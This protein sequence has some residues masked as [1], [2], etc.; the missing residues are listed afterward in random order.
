MNAKSMALSSWGS[1]FEAWAIHPELLN[2]LETQRQSRLMLWC[3]VLAGPALLLVI[4]LEG[5][6]SGDYTRMLVVGIG[7]VLTCSMVV[8]LRF[9]RSLQ[10][11]SMLLTLFATAQLFSAAWWTGGISSP[12]I[13]VYPLATIF[14]A[15][16]GTIWMSLACSLLLLLGMLG[17]FYLELNSMLPNAVEPLM[18]VRIVITAWAILT[19]L[20][21]AIFNQKQN[22]LHLRRISDELQRRTLAQAEAER[23][24]D[25]WEGFLNY[26][27]HELRNPLTTISGSLELIAMT[28]DEQ[29]RERYLR[30]LGL[31]SGRLASLAD[32]V[33]DYATLERGKLQLRPQRIDLAVVL[34]YC[35]EE[36]SSQTPSGQKLRLIAAESIVANVD[37]DRVSQILGN[38]ISNAIKY[39]NGTDIVLELK[40]TGADAVSIFVSDSGPGVPVELQGVL[41]EAFSRAAGTNRKGTGLGLSIALHLAQAMRGD[42]S[43]LDTPAPGAHFQLRLPLSSSSDH[44]DAFVCND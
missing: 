4:L 32:D 36:W 25:Q 12:V 7:H 37:P 3:C 41:F 28:S 16:I 31:A 14:L 39:G 11:P 18:S 30:S 20:A 17:V 43:L 44:S 15:M 29:R 21:V 2:N 13:G 34:K 42:L 1:R 9:S 40:R 5:M 38:L 23:L 19:G 10:F 24:R 8:S 26:V 33:L 35:L 22:A 27:S 6:H